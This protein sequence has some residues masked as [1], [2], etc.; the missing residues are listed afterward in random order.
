VI[1]SAVFHRNSRGQQGDNNL[2]KRTLEETMF[3]EYDLRGVFGQELTIGFA[4][5]LGA[6]CC[7]CLRE[8]LGKEK[9]VTAWAGHA[10]RI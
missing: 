6:V 9:F 2:Q 5:R 8:R 4:K 3:R 10:S 1:E 7:A